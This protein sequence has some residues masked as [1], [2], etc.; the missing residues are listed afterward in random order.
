MTRRAGGKRFRRITA[1]G[2]V[3]LAGW[4]LATAVV[5][6][7]SSIVSMLIDTT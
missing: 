6:A 5:A 2:I 7:A 3:L 4:A 1:A